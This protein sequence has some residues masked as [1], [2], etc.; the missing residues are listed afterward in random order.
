[1]LWSTFSN[2][3]SCGVRPKREPMEAIIFPAATITRNAGDETWPRYGLSVEAPSRSTSAAARLNRATDRQY[4]AKASTSQAVITRLAIKSGASR[5][6][7]ACAS[8]SSWTGGTMVPSEGRGSWRQRELHRAGRGVSQSVARSIS[9]LLLSMFVVA[10]CVAACS[11]SPPAPTATKTVTVTAPSAPPPAPTPQTSVPP[12]LAGLGEEVQNGRL[13]FMVRGVFFR[14]F[15]LLS[16][17][18]PTPRHVFGGVPR[19][20]KHRR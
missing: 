19:R 16:E 17:R 15:R 4:I 5:F 7:T 18:H 14:E 20:K 10:I 11:S 13:A 1:M 9:R 8:S 2:A 6:H 12:P 3:L